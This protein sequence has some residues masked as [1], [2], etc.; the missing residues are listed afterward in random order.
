[1]NTEKILIIDDN[2]ALSEMFA[3][4]VEQGGYTP[5]TESDAE[6][7]ISSFHHKGPFDLVLVNVGQLDE[8]KFAIV[9]QLRR[10][11]KTT[12]IW[13]YSGMMDNDGK[14]LAAKAKATKALMSFDVM[15][16]LRKARFAQEMPREIIKG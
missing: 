3:H 13:V 9:E 6:E 2:E 16:E 8:A 15:E 4:A 5:T 1:M 10:V 14:K 12:P 7:G 11:D